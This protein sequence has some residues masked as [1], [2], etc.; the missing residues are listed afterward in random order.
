[1]QSQTDPFT[2]LSYADSELDLGQSSVYKLDVCVSAQRVSLCIY[3]GMRI[4]GLKVLQSGSALAGHPHLLADGLKSTGWTGH[5]FMDTT[6]Y[7]DTSRFTL[8]PE[9]LFESDKAATYL[10]LVHRPADN[11]QVLTS[12]LPGHSATCVFGIDKQ[13]YASL[14]ALFGSA[15]FGHINTVLT[16]IAAHFNG[17]E[18]K[19]HL[20]VTVNEGFISVLCYQNREVRFLNTFETG[21]DT[22]IVYFILSV[23]SL[24]KLPSDRFGVILAGDISS[25]STTCSLLKKYIPE[26][27]TI[28]RLE[29]VRYPLSFREFQDQQHYLPIHTLLCG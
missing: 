27:L 25:T 18:L 23:A 29:D 7:I 3:S 26:V 13:V 20:L 6:V 22:D 17:N 9:A 4:Y 14:R 12:K 10:N 2:T 19:H 21:S 8:V 1:M 28:N 24:L 16:S 15:A 5:T 11:E